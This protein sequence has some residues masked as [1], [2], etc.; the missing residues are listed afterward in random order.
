MYVFIKIVLPGQGSGLQLSYVGP[1]QSL[2]PCLGSIS[3]ILLRTPVPHDFEQTPQ[4][5]HLQC[6]ER[7]PTCQYIF[8]NV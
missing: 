6:T 8:S 2:P 7:K 5:F 1:S 4:S 3:I